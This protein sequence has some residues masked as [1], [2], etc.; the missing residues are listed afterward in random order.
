[1]IIQLAI[2]E[3]TANISDTGNFIF[4]MGPPDHYIYTV[5]VF[6]SD[7]K[8]FNHLAWFTI[9]ALTSENIEIGSMNFF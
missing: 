5:V 3:R 4:G 1:M 6:T 9:S 2:S 8:K 7:V